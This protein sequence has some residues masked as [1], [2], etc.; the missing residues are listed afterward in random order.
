MVRLQS[1]DA[2]NIKTQNSTIVFS[3]DQ[4]THANLTVSDSPLGGA[5]RLLICSSNDEYE[6]V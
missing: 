6:V 1:V 4:P 2:K 5:I 3:N